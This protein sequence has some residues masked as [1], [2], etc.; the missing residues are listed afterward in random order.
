MA[1]LLAE[2]FRFIGPIGFVITGEQFSG[3]FDGGALKTT[4]FALTNVEVREHEG[5]AVASGVW[6]Q[7]TSFQGSPNNGNFRFSGVFTR[8]ADGWNLLHAQLSPMMVLP[9]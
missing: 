3:R 8:E 5:T 4:R 1:A 9:A 7:E 2:D 6:T